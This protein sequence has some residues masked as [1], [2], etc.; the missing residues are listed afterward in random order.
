MRSTIEVVVSVMISKST[1]VH[2]ESWF[3]RSL[4]ELCENR[5]QVEEKGQNV[6]GRKQGTSQKK[7]FMSE[8]GEAK[9]LI[10]IVSQNGY[11]LFFFPHSPPSILRNCNH[12]ILIANLL[13]SSC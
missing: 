12:M 13:H 3:W 5:A 11:A 6:T 7:W 10:V 1:F 2:I 4:I 9:P 8:L